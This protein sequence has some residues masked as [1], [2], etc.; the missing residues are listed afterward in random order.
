MTHQVRR[1]QGA[2]GADDVVVVGGLGVTDVP[3][4]GRG[5]G[6]GADQLPMAAMMPTP[7]LSWLYF[8]SA[9]WPITV[10]LWRPSS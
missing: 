3:P 4:S 5:P 2:A 9:L 10:T 7:R 8:T 1:C 6:R